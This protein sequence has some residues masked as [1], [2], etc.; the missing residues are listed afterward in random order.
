MT[1]SITGAS[2]AEYHGFESASMFPYPIENHCIASPVAS[3]VPTVSR[4][5]SPYTAISWVSLKIKKYIGS[6]K[7][8]YAF[9]QLII[10]R[11]TLGIYIYTAGS[12]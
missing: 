7:C 10:V 1:A 12:A 9:D 3:A 2:I 5:N 8:T 4:T 6:G 11:E